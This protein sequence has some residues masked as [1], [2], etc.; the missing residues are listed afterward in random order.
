MSTP[1]L[2]DLISA[3]AGLPGAMLPILHAIQEALGYVPPDAIPL[4][5]TALNRSRAEVHGV[6]TFY[7]TFRAEPTGR[8]VVQVCRG[9][10]CLAVGAEGLASHVKRAVGCDDHQTSADGAVTLE[11]VYCLG[12]CACGP[13][14]RVDDEVKGRVDQASFDA[15]LAE[16]R[17]LES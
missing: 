15:L 6:L 3:H 10:A 9:E 4:I 7:P 1:A 17:E 2:Q 8:H 14:I 16:L 11:P 12:N 13:S 5:A